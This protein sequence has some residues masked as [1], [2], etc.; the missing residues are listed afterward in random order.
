MAVYYPDGG[1]GAYAQN[2]QGRQDDQF[3]Q[4]LQMMMMGMQEKTRKQ[5]YTDQLQQ[6]QVE[7]QRKNYELGLN[8]RRTEAT[9]RGAEARM[10][11][12]NKPPKETQW[13][14]RQKKAAEMVASK[15]LTT[16][17][18]DI[19]ALTGKIP[20]NKD[21]TTFQEITV[22]RN[23][24]K[25][26][27][28]TIGRQL[29]RLTGRIAKMENPKSITEIAMGLASGASL[30]DIGSGISVD[31][32]E[33]KRLRGISSEL[34][35]LISTL[36]ERDLT[37]AESK[38]INSLLIEASRPK[39]DNTKTKHVPFEKPMKYE[40]AM[41]GGSEVKDKFGYM[42][43]QEKADDQGVVWIYK[44]NNSWVKK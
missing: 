29:S 18:G 27:Q 39:V 10:I 31:T 20:G 15:Y 33:I 44:G 26:R 42:L 2:Q 16:E 14:W 1:P 6:Q 9:E 13:E 4:I 19:Y 12:A 21:L 24:R 8:E 43:N 38:R 23:R 11:T 28:A 7:N 32:E 25:D 36:D 30:Q 3:R 5:Q 37:A 35:L 17:E 22:E 40:G 41:P 34:E